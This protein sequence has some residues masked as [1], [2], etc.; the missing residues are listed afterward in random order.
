MHDGF[1]ITRNYKNFLAAINMAE[2]RAAR[3]AGYVL[4][5]GAPG[6]GKSE[7]VA[8]YSMD[9]K[10]VLIRAKSTSTRR[11]ILDELADSLGLPKSGRT[12][13]VQNRIITYLVSHP[14]DDQQP[15][16]IVV[17]EA[18][19][20]ISLYSASLEVIRDITDMTGSV[21]VIV[22][23]ENIDVAL[24]RH[25]QI[26][27]R[28]S[29]TVEFIALTEADVR[30]TCKQKCRVA[31]ADDAAA[32]IFRASKGRMRL[33][34]NAIAKIEQVASSNSLAKVTAADI[35]DVDL[36]FEWQSRSVKRG[37]VRKSLLSGHSADQSLTQLSGS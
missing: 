11:G 18:D 14:G 27:S 21:C 7:A 34:L 31:V 37:A 22:G 35:A 25:P 12:A 10:A 33:I 23:M 17:D 6:L 4:V 26:A 3:E 1:V 5:T 30:S 28:I 8:R 15:R 29:A 24:S 13:D 36:C 32:L 19:H 20:T 2:S 9:K 16:P